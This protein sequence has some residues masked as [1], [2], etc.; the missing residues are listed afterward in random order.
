M[1]GFKETLLFFVYI[2]PSSDAPQ[3]SIKASNV[4]NIVIRE[5]NIHGQGVFAAKGC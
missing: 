4:K 2:V 3:R 1:T 5:S